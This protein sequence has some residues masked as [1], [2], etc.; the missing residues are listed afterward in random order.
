MR[1]SSSKGTPTSISAPAIMSP[2]APEKQSRYR[3]LAIVRD[4]DYS[5]PPSRK[6]K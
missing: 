4:Q 5:R 1:A 3:I 2:A 6:L